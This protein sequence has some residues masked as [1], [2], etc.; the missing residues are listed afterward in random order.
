MLGGPKANVYV[1]VTRDDAQDIEG[2]H[3][4]VFSRAQAAGFFQL[5]RTS[6]ISPVYHTEKTRSRS[7][8]APCRRTGRTAWRRTASR[9]TLSS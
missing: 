5:S 8:S 9:V 3:D 7:T 6:T 1:S 4:H 2:N